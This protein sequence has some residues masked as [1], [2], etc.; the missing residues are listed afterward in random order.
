MQDR[1]LK[2]TQYQDRAR[3]ASALAEASSLDHVRRKHELAAAR[4]RELAAMNEFDI[5]SST[6]RT[7]LPDETARS[8]DARSGP[9]PA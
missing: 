7:G 6:R 5:A 2:T 4:W 1:E 3:D 8:S 9:L